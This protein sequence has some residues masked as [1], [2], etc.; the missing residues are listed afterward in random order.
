MDFGD[1][2]TPVKQ[3]GQESGKPWSNLI[4]RRVLDS[5]IKLG[6]NFCDHFASGLIIQSMEMSSTVP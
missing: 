6:E 3:D 2:F 5:K 4:G 1:K